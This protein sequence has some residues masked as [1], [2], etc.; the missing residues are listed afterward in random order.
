M[1]IKINEMH[2]RTGKTYVKMEDFVRELDKRVREFKERGGKYDPTDTVDTLY[3]M[4]DENLR[5]DM[6]RFKLVGDEK[7]MRV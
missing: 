6:R 7:A 1:K 2:A 4:M 3:T 5:R